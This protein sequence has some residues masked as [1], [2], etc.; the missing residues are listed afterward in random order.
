MQASHL[1]RG[2][3]LLTA[4]ETFDRFFSELYPHDNQFQSLFSK[5]SIKVTALARYILAEINNHLSPGDTNNP[6]ANGVDADLEHILPKKYKDHWLQLA[7]KFPGGHSKYVN[8]LGNMTLITPDQ[9]RRLGNADFE[10]KKR[11]YADKCLDVT[12]RLLDEPV[13]SAEAISRRQNWLASEAIKI[14]RF[15]VT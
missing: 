5:K 2:N 7:T 6:E 15:P 8:R 11:V 14:W 3:E 10:T 9:N 1:I 12:K 13:W 4:N